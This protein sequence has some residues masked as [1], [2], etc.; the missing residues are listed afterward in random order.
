MLFVILLFLLILLLIGVY[1]LFRA[2]KWTL[3]K[4]I[5]IK[6]ALVIILV[7]AVTN[8]IKVV[9][10]T[11]MEF[12]RSNVY[13][14]LYLIKN[15]VNNRDSIHKAIEEMVL[16]KVNTE[17]LDKLEANEFSENLMNTSS[18]RFRFYEYY[19]GTFFLIP[20][21]EAG[22]KHFIE[23][24]EDP[25]GFS[26]EELSHYNQYRIAE[27]NVGYCKNDTLHYVGRLNY[28]QG[29][30]VIKTDTLFNQCIINKEET[31]L[32]DAES[33]FDGD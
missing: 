28:Y 31:P 11:K 25:E 22:T 21:G 16:K 33:I 19:T 10:F 27:F 4:K 6:W 30:D 20:F 7:V 1:L 12:I 18:Y 2:I 5:R 17:L 23:N 15:P 29:W 26:S 3:K 9:F 14:N 8:L 24:E 13:P 32:E